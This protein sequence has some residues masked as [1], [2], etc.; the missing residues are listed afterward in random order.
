LFADDEEVADQLLLSLT[1]RISGE[2]YFLDVPEPNSSAARLVNRYNM[3]TVFETARMY[4]GKAPSLSLD[5]IFGVTSF[6]LG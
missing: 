3:Q 2:E 5:K 4:S 6:E 1:G